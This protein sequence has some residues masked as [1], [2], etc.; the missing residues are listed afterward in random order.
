MKLKREWFLLV[1]CLAVLSA[2]TSMPSSGP[3]IDE[4]RG[5]STFWQPS[6]D[7]VTVMGQA[8]PEMSLG[9]GTPTHPEA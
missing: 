6:P 9:D 1:P 7:N 8:D 2:C 4:I 5:R 3:S